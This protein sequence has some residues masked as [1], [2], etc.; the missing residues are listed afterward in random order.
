MA[1]QAAT[2]ASFRGN[3][4]GNWCLLAEPLMRPGCIVISSVFGQHV[5]Q[6]TLVE[7]QQVVQASFPDGANPALR[8][9]VGFGR[10]EW[11]QHDF[12][13]FGDKDVIKGSRE[14]GV[15]VMDEKAH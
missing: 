3:A 15:V 12:D 13:A 8:D 4:K 11:S 6:V 1:D 2:D 14:F 5:D 7:N 9:G 10:L